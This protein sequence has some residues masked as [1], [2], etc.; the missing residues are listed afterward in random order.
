[1]AFSADAATAASRP[2]AAQ[3]F[4]R[5]WKRWL[6]LGAC[7]GLGYGL[8]QRLLSLRVDTTWNGRQRFEVKPFPGTELDSLRRRFGD[9]SMEIRGDLDLLELERQQKRE[10]AAIEKRRNEMEQRER[11]RQQA[12]PEESAPPPAADAA[13]ERPPAP[14]SPLLP[15]LSEPDP[16]PPEP[17]PPPPG[18]PPSPTP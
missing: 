8:T 18:A 9:A 10:A 6:L 11:E 16:L 7:F 13:V 1:M 17:L 14:E 15:P 12:P 4:A 5:R 3:A 2:R